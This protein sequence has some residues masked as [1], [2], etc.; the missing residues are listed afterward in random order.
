MQ[1]LDCWHDMKHVQDPQQH[2][3]AHILRGVFVVWHTECDITRRYRPAFNMFSTSIKPS[4]Y[5]SSLQLAAVQFTTFWF[6]VNLYT[7]K[8]V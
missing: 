1:T 2:A 8:F 5:M 3:C 4:P 7:Y 6:D